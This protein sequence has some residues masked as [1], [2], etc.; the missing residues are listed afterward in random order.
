MQ[1]GAQGPK[2]TA[3]CDNDEASVLWIDGSLEGSQDFL[4]VG[5]ANVPPT[6]ATVSSMREPCA[7]HRTGA[8]PPLFY[9]AWHQPD[10]LDVSDPKH[11]EAGVVKVDNMS[12]AVEVTLKC[13]KPTLL[14]NANLSV[15]HFA[16]PSGPFASDAKLLPYKGAPGGNMVPGAPS[17][18]PSSPPLYADCH[19]Y[20][21]ANP[22]ATSGIYK[23]NPGNGVNEFSV[24]CDMDTIKGMGYT[25]IYRVS[26]GG[27]AGCSTG[28]A[29]GYFSSGG[30]GGSSIIDNSITSSE[31]GSKAAKLSDTQINALKEA[32]GGDNHQVSEGSEAQGVGTEC[33]LV[34]SALTVSVAK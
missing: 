19:G 11:A 9:C 6:C 13:P 14:N 27:C 23:I 26:K 24:F 32:I 5:L 34:V 16:D 8:I 30:L 4:L 33:C 22:D 18:P 12:L 17:P 15:Y 21:V 7:A 25:V 10:G 2:L 20:K 28:D 31:F 3:A 1:F 29:T